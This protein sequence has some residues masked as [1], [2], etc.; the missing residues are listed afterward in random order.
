MVHKDRKRLNQSPKDRNDFLSSLDSLFHLKDHSVIG[1]TD[2]VLANKH[3]TTLGGVQEREG[4][5]A[6]HSCSAQGTAK[7][8]ECTRNQQ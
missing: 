6:E 5:D 7:I 8:T 2:V 4:N 3:K 1:G